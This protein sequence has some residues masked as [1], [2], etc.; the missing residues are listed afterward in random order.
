MA[1]WREPRDWWLDLTLGFPHSFQL[2]AFRIGLICGPSGAAKS[3]LLATHFGPLPRK[4]DW[5]HAVPLSQLFANEA[6]AACCLAAVAAPLPLA[7]SW[8][9][10]AC[11]AG[12][13]AMAELAL[14]LAETEPD[15]VSDEGGA[16][17][18][19]EGGGGELRSPSAP[20][21]FDEFGSAWDDATTARVGAALSQVPAALCQA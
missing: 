4:R 20:G 3:A 9:P 15:E 12:E 19:G 13:V 6:Q 18:A 5:P 21:L 11:S 2:G 17:H 14:L 7:L 1:Q 10:G 16:M 8:Q